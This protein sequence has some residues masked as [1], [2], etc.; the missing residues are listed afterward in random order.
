MEDVLR[1]V[2]EHVLH[3][4]QRLQAGDVGDCSTTCA[5]QLLEQH[6]VASQAET[7]TSQPDKVSPLS[8]L[9]AYPLS[10]T[11]NQY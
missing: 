2:A 11:P 1:E 3:F 7:K 5:G 10:P 8:T 4:K 9:V 6:A